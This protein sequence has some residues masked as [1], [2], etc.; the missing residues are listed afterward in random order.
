MSHYDLVIVEFQVL[1][2]LNGP[3]ETASCGLRAGH[4]LQLHCA[5]SFGETFQPR[6]ACTSEKPYLI[7]F[8]YF[9]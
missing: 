2:C 4:G 8:H 1:S 5:P 3:Q 9:L 6:Q 7:L